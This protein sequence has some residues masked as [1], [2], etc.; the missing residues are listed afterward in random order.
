MMSVDPTYIAPTKEGLTQDAQTWAAK[1]H[2]LRIV[3]RESYLQV[4]HLLQSVKGLRN[5]IVKWFSPFVEAAMETK[6]KAEAARKGLTDEQGRMEAPLVEAE[7]RLKRSL[8][9]WDTAQERL[10]QDEERRLQIEANRRA[11]ALTLEVAAALEKEANAL[12]DAEMLQEARDIFAQ[13][14]ETPVVTVAKAMP[15]VQGVTYRD[16]WKAHDDIDLVALAAGVGNG[17]IPANFVLPNLP[18]LHAFARATKGTAKVPGVK[19]YN[20]RIIAAK[21]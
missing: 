15:K 2:G 18:A 12:G 10:R 9:D 21:A 13:P 5:E 4:S 14:I 20:D 1:A 19:F 16:Q 11:E 7:S 6:R 17:S 8:L 3:D